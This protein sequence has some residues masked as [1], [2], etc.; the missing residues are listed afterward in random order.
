MRKTET[1]LT[2]IIVY[3]GIWNSWPKRGSQIAVFLIKKK[4]KTKGGNSRNVYWTGYKVQG[5]P[6][7]LPFSACLANCKKGLSLFVFQNENWGSYG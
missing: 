4:V 1:P 6:G 7:S 3:S 5:Y 2:E